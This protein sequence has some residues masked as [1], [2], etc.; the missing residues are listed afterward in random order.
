MWSQNNF[1][2]GFS[3]S[4]QKSSN[5]LPINDKFKL[6]K[7]INTHTYNR[8]RHIPTANLKNFKCGG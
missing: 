3:F 7:C 1:A 4:I 8:H 5:I 2:I 6:L